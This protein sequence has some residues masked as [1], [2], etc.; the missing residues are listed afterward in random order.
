MADEPP[1]AVSQTDDDSSTLP[2]KVVKTLAISFGLT[3]V[4]FW[5][6]LD[7]WAGVGPHR[8]EMDPLNQLAGGNRHRMILPVALRACRDSGGLM[9]GH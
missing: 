5:P 2:R 7:Q 4:N 9:L 6:C 8:A 3:A 1:A